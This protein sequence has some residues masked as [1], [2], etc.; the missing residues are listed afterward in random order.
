MDVEDD[1]FVMQILFNKRFICKVLLLI[2][3]VRSQI[4]IIN[5]MAWWFY[6][7]KEYLIVKIGRQTWVIRPLQL[8]N[9]LISFRNSWMD[10][11]YLIQIMIGGNQQ[12][13]AYVLAVTIIGVL[14]LSLTNFS[15]IMLM[16]NQYT[17]RYWIYFPYLKIM[18]GLYGHQ[19]WNPCL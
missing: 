10:M 8:T 1:W 14:Q 11:M 13:Y 5:N 3:L 2:D 17:T 19:I 4:S 15:T 9:T 16:S 18:L 12:V 7:W 6:Q